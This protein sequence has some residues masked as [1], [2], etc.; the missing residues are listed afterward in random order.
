MQ[1]VSLSGLSG[2]QS[3]CVVTA[4]VRKIQTTY[5]NGDKLI[6]EYDAKSDELTCTKPSF[7]SFLH[8]LVSVSISQLVN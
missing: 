4:G 8:D 2:G 1:A 6:E 3:T 5:P 7:Q